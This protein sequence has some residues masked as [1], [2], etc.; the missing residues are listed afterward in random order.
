MKGCARS[1]RRRYRRSRPPVFSQAL[2]A[3]IVRM[4]TAMMTI[5]MTTVGIGLVEATDNGDSSFPSIVIGAVP[6]TETQQQSQNG[7]S[8]ST[9]YDRLRGS[10]TVPRPSPL[11]SGEVFPPTGA[12]GKYGL[13]SDWREAA[14]MPGAR[15]GDAT[16]RGDVCMEDAKQRQVREIL[17]RRSNTP[18]TSKVAACVRTKDFGRFLPEWIAYHYAIG[19]DEMTIFDDDSIDDTVEIIQP[20]VDAGIVHYVLER[21]GHWQNQ[22]APLNRCLE[23]HMARRLNDTDTDAPRWLLFHDTDEYI[24]PVDTSITISQALDKHSSTCC[25]RVPRVTYGAGGHYE[26]PQGLLLE[27]FLDHAPV[28]DFKKNRLP[29]VMVNLDTTQPSLGQATSY[30]KSMHNGQGCVCDVI[31]VG[32]IR[33]NHYLGSLGDY[34]EKT[35]RY[36]QEVYSREKIEKWVID[37]DINTMKSDTITTW[38]CATRE[39]LSVLL[40]GGDLNKVLPVTEE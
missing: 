38:A 24:L 10:M 29:K 17:E 13:S 12:G 3:W 4:A 16:M 25:V 11:E 32:E 2:P 40:E 31:P 39:V 8:S 6:S 37:R 20:F 14:M 28:H 22:L 5:A 19:V 26:M 21:T 30:L 35:K 15:G 33:I 27:I 23:E 7:V 34:R 1:S 18:G 9:R 36:W